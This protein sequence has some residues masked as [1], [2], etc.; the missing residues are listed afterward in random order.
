[1]GVTTRG[2]TGEVRRGSTPPGWWREDSRCTARKSWHS[3]WMMIS[4]GWSQVR[5]PGVLQSPNRL[6]ARH[7]Q[8]QLVGGAA[9][10]RAGGVG[11]KPATAPMT[12]IAGGLMPA[13]LVSAAMSARVP[14]TDCW[15]GIA[16]SATVIAGVSAAS[17]CLINSAVMAGSVATPIMIT[18]VVLAVASACQLRVE[19]GSPGGAWPEI[20]VKPWVSSRWVSGT[21]ANAGPAIAEETPG[22]TVTGNARGRAGLPLLTA[23]AEDEGVATLEPDDC[24]AR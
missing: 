2:A 4:W 17:P 9:D 7:Q 12:V 8:L 14:R 5:I 16:A 22:I 3:G 13:S 24:L 21:P 6:R 15:L 19:P 18:K 1:M 20:T 11:L 10:S 23:A